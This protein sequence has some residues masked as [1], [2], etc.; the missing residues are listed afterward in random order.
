MRYDVQSVNWQNICYHHASPRQSMRSILPTHAHHTYLSQPRKL[1]K[2]RQAS[3]C[4]RPPCQLLHSPNICS[5][6]QF[7]AIVKR[8]TCREWPTASP[9]SLHSGSKISFQDSYHVVCRSG[10]VCNTMLCW[11]A[12]HQV[13][14][15]RDL[16]WLL[17]NRGGDLDLARPNEGNWSAPNAREAA[18]RRPS[19]W[20]QKAVEEWQATHEG[21]TR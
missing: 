9:W 10:S 15:A 17:L 1:G 20:F 18:L 19:T 4:A 5:C 3:C 13:G 16:I 11:I 6:R 21:H 14:D 12:C 7:W 8:T 2:P